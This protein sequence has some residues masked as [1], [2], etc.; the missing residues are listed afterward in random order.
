MAND[1]AIEE[2]EEQQ[3]SHPGG[4]RFNRLL[5]ISFV[6]IAMAGGVALALGIQS[7]AFSPRERARTRLRRKQLT[8]PAPLLATAARSKTSRPTAGDY[9]PLLI[10]LRRRQSSRVFRHQ[11]S[12]A[13]RSRRVGMH[14]G[15]RTST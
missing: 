4:G 7:S 10:P 11:F 1:D 13:L 15:P 8:T 2:L 6:V 14:S 3:D 5:G 12:T 9:I